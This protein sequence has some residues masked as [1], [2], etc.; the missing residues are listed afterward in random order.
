MLSGTRTQVRVPGSFPGLISS[1]LPYNHSMSSDTSPPTGAPLAERL[2][3]RSLDAIVGQEHLVGPDRPLRRA[4]ESGNLHSMILW[5]PPGSG[6][7][8]L[9]LA[10]AGYT[11]AR[12]VRFSAVSSGVRD[13]REVVAALPAPHRAV[14]VLFY[15]ETLSL[16]EIA[17][18]LDLPVGTVKSR[19]HYARERLRE[20]V[21]R[22]QRPLPEMTY[23]F[24]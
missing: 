13:V 22:R 9:A 21:L 17:G 23:E 16:E 4:I 12:F 6:K 3:P 1:P 20:M 24:T 7:T 15:M 11:K 5:G 18:V 10:M 19:L 14:V 2:R 8:T